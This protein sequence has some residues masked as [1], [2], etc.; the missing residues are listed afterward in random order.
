MMQIR[1]IL[2]AAAALSACQ[3]DGQPSA[4]CG[5][6]AL[7]GPLVALE[8]FA[9]G[10]GMAGVPETVPPILPGRFV[11][12]PVVSVLLSRGDSALVAAV[13]GPRPE[14]SKAGFGVLVTNQEQQPMGVLIYDGAVIPGAIQVGTIQVGDT[15][16]PLLGLRVSP[17]T[18]EDARCPLFPT[19]SE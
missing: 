1:T 2:I 19:T 4:A 9:R 17:G 7:T 18:I 11:A 10:D 8:G 12:G 16:L 5:I 13:D 3:G 15:L 6:A 14:G